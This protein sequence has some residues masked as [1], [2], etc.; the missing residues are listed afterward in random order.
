MSCHRSEPDIPAVFTPAPASPTPD[1]GHSGWELVWQDEFD[2]PVLDRSKWTPE[3]G[4]HG[5]GNAESQYYTD[6]PEN[7]F[8]KDGKLIIHVQK[9]P[10]QGKRFTSARL[11]T[12]DLFAQAYGRFEARI[13]IPTGQGIWPAFWLLG[14]DISGVGWPQCGEI[15]IMENIGREPGVVY[16]TL[17]GPGYAGAENIGQSISLPDG[18]RY[19]D[20][21][22]L[23]A[24]EWD[25]A[26]IRWYV[27]DSLYQ[28][29]RLEDVPGE[30]VYDHPFFIL[31]NV[32]VGGYWPG[33]PDET[34]VFPQRMIIDYVR[35]YQRPDGA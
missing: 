5:W 35:V 23:Y 6:R 13:R 25:P 16:G 24:V 12:K 18:E 21:F 17:H 14:D 8:I 15:D 9:E 19:A 22:H 10:F 33:Y 2:Q 28:T 26:E 11:I 7:A 27:D 1:G 31:L 29:V 32:A 4:G 20:D 34:T 3:T 30:W